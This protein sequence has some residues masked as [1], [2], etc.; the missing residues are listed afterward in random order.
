[1]KV[2][3]DNSGSGEVRKDLLAICDL[4]RT[5]W[6]IGEMLR[7][8]VETLM[9]RINYGADK[10]RLVWAFNLEEPAVLKK[11]KRRINK[12]NASYYLNEMLPIAY[13]NPYLRTFEL[14]TSEIAR[15]LIRDNL[16]SYYIPWGIGRTTYKNF[17]H[18]IEA[19]HKQH[20][21]VPQLSCRPNTLLWAHRF[22]EKHIG[23]FPITVNLRK[24]DGVGKGRSSS[25]KDWGKFFK[26][27]NRKKRP[28]FKFII[29]SRES[30]IYKP[31]RSLG[32]VFFSKDFGTNIEQDLALIQ[33]SALF[34]GCPSGMNQMAWFTDGPYLIFGSEVIFLGEQKAIPLWGQLPFASSLQRLVWKPDTVA[35]LVEEFTKFLGD[36]QKK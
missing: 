26:T 29:I 33:C 24:A 8:Q 2:W 5:T 28:Q 15:D 10:I 1:M 17:Y 12:G 34:M 22:L 9:Y 21:F 14:V 30:E 36:L 16:D 7:F 3:E 6:C 32:N 4:S 25:F 27:F 18:R 31:F 20:N 11:A 23:N 19:F 13:V 35:V